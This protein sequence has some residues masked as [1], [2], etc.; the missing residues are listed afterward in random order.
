MPYGLLADQVPYRA[1]ESLLD[2][3]SGLDSQRPADQILD[4]PKKLCGC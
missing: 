3:A 1:L 2:E 4:S